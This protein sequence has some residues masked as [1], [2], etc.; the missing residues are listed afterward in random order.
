MIELV[1]TFGVLEMVAPCKRDHPSILDSLKIVNPYAHKVVPKMDIQV[2]GSPKTTLATLF[3]TAVLAAAFTIFLNI[4]LTRQISPTI[5]YAGEGSLISRLHVPVKY[6]KDPI[7][8]LCE[9]R[10]ILG[11]VFCVD[12]FITQ[13][14]FVLGPNGNREVLRATEDHLSFWEQV[15]WAMGPVLERGEYSNVHQEAAIANDF[16]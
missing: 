15:R 1:S 2:L 9:S 6:A 13:F 11:D 3:A 10:R 7:N 4:K 14:V 5:R 8:F 12:L 16:I